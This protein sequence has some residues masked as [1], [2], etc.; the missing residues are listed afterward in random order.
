M[1]EEQGA[2]DIGENAIVNCDWLM[3]TMIDL[4]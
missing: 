1:T 3:V 2:L 4:K